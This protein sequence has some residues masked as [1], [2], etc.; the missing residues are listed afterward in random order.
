MTFEEWIKGIEVHE[1]LQRWMKLAWTAS[2][3]YEKDHHAPLVEA[4]E[5]AL[6]FLS[7][8]NP[9]RDALKALKHD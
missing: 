7:T 8:D 6:D 2:A 5:G 3:T 1:N 4:A 9:L